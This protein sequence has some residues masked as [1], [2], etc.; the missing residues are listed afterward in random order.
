MC[1]RMMEILG[2]TK[3]TVPYLKEQIITG[4]LAP[5]RKLNEIQISSHLGMSRPP[6]REVFRVLEDEH[7]VLGP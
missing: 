6:L 3:S 1:K 2:V 4:E 7:P 5:G